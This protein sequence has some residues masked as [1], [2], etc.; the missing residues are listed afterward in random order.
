MEELSAQKSPLFLLPCFCLSIF[1]KCNWS[2]SCLGKPQRCNQIWVAHNG[3]RSSGAGGCKESLGM[4]QGPLSRAAWR[5][6]LCWLA[7]GPGRKTSQFTSKMSE[8]LGCRCDDFCLKKHCGCL[9]AGTSAGSHICD[10]FSV[11]GGF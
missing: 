4:V 3:L 6:P 5:V 9:Q 8:L 7:T 11:F 1:K 10:G 2:K